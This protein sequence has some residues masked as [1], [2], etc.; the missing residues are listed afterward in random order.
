MLR[1]M[2]E[3]RLEYARKDGERFFDA[4]QNARV[5]A[6]AERYYRAMYY[7]S[8]ASWNLRDA[9]MFDTLQSLLAFY[10]PDS[11]RHRLGA[12]L[13]RRRRRARPR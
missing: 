4:A 3:R 2:L 8:A 1:D 9:H 10:G 13:A 12:Q 7:G 11:Q 6:N 5:V